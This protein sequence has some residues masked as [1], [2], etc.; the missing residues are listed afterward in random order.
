MNYVKE[1]NAPYNDF[2][3]STS[4]RTETSSPLTKEDFKQVVANAPLFAIDL[5]V[6]N[7]QSQILVGERKNAP[8][9]GYWF[10]PGGRVYKNESLEKAFERISQSE[11][12]F[13]VFRNNA[14]FLGLYDHFYNDNV[15]DKTTSTHY[16]NAAHWVRLEI[17]NLPNIP[18]EQHQNYRWVPWHTIQSDD[19]IHRFSKVFIDELKK[20]W[21]HY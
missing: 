14:E 9:K 3:E 15:F 20:R 1:E 10:V 7:S 17:D 4:P 8:A 16:I 6:M 18:T 13:V 11:L 12:G 21:R 5:V 2:S 19:S